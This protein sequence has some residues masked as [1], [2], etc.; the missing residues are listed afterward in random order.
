MRIAILNLTA[1]GMSGGY[2]KYLSNMLPRFS[3]R[4]DIEKILCAYP[5]GF[6]ID[7]S[8]IS[9]E[10]ILSVFCKPYSP[11]AIVSDH[12]L[13]NNLHLFNP[14]VIFIPM[15]RYFQFRRVPV[16]NMVRNMFPLTYSSENP[17]HEKI[18]NVFLE[19][20]AHRVV[21]KAQRTIAVSYYVQKYL[22]ERWHIS[23]SHVPVIYHG[24]EEV[25]NQ[26]SVRPVLIPQERD[27]FLFT[28]GSIDP[29]RGLEDILTALQ[30]LHAQGLKIK[31]VIA[32]E[33]RK[34]MASYKR[35]LQ[36]FLVQNKIANQ[37]CWTGLLKASEMAWC[38]KNCQAFI[39]TTRV[40]ACPNI[41]LEAMAHGSVIISTDNMPLPEFF[42]D[43][44]YYYPSRNAEYLAEEIKKILALDADIR[45]NIAEK[46]R[47]RSRDFS[48]DRTAQ[49]TIEELKKAIA[50]LKENK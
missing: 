44:A 6:S 25:D 22:I 37:V 48:W 19:N 18:R 16:V 46:A 4:D 12:A 50:S 14:D 33:A 47:M 9:S 1:G 30:V 5:R 13:I 8:L 31:L 38:Y 41:A 2:R 7:N 49:K 20:V 23:P 10:K 36:K 32:G 11:C 17:F 29:Y 43:A 15:E 39:A 24:V 40:E 42:G 27:K 3:Q 35:K 28:A 21:L 26:K 45:S 34:V